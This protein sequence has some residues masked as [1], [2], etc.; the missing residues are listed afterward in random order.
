MATY[1]ERMSD[2]ADEQ[3][4]HLQAQG[5]GLQSLEILERDDPL[6]LD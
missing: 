3:V 4:P 6:N 5:L 1:W 2:G